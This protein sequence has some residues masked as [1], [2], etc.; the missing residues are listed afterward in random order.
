MENKDLLPIGTKV[1]IRDNSLYKLQGYDDQNKN[2][3]VGEI[4]RHYG[5]DFDYLVKWD[6]SE[7]WLYR[8]TDVYPIE[9]QEINKE[10]VNNELK[11]LFNQIFNN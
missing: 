5:A 4:T 6:N 8:E 3:M 9:E 11:Q 10:Q 2:K 1:Y 7:E